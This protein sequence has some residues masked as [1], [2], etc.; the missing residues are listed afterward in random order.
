MTDIE[1]AVSP[2]ELLCVLTN[3]LSR[4]ISLGKHGSFQANHILGRPY[5]HTFEIVDQ[6]DDIFQFPLRI[7]PAAELNAEIDN[8]ESSTPQDETN[9]DIVERGCGVEYDVIDAEGKAVMRTNRRTIDDTSRQRLSMDDIEALKR[10]ETGSGKEL[11]AKILESHSALAQKTAFALAKYTLRKAK[12]YLRRFT[13]LPLD[14]PLLTNWI[15]FEKEPM[16]TMEIREEILALIGSWSNVHYSNTIY[17]DSASEQSTTGRGGRWLVVDETGGLLVAAMAERMGILYPS[18][19]DSTN[20]SDELEAAVT[21]NDTRLDEAQPAVTK[22]V[23]GPN[24][25]ATHKPAMSADSN[26]IT[27]LHSQSQPNLSLLTYFGF[28]MTNPTRTHPLYTHM[29]TISWLQ[30]LSPNDYSGYTEP[31]SFPDEI[32]QTWRSG[33][34]GTYY[35][36]RRRWERVKSVIDQTRAGGFDGLIIA[37]VMSPATILHHAVPLLRGA[38]QVVVY[39]PTVEPLAEL[40]DYYSTARRTAYLTHTHDPTDIPNDDFPLNPTLLLAPTIQTA[41]CRRWQVLPG[42]THPLMTSRGGAEGYVFTGT[43]VLPA[44]GKIEARGAYKRRKLGVSGGPGSTNVKEESETP[45]S[46]GNE[47][48]VAL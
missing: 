23:A 45:G 25:H 12:K 33:K 14:V 11:I 47:A 22:P 9:G 30:L 20:A 46:P 16:K 3:N 44:E 19:E 4:T 2:L 32:I 15:L 6:T 18:R 40:V 21:H 48:A 43:R 41:Q 1:R 38:A 42:R 10:E 29:R 34:K 28:D 35:R 24:A 7:V 26:N 37:S 31:E 13:V 8:D 27:V 5:H 36:K 39:S 17:S